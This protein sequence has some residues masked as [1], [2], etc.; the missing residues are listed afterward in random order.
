MMKIDGVRGPVF[1]LKDLL[2]VF[3]T[4]TKLPGEHRSGGCLSPSPSV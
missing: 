1:G 4:C 3:V 2:R